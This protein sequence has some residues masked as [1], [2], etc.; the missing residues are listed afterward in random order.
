MKFKDNLG[1]VPCMFPTDL[2]VYGAIRHYFGDDVELIARSS[3]TPRETRVLAS[4]VL[5]AYKIAIFVMPLVG[6]DGN[7]WKAN[8]AKRNGFKVFTVDKEDLLN[9]EL[10]NNLMASIKEYMLDIDKKYRPM[11]INCSK[12][13]FDAER[14]CY[15]CRKNYDDESFAFDGTKCGNYYDPDVTEERYWNV[16]ELKYAMFKRDSYKPAVEYYIQKYEKAGLIEQKKQLEFNGKKCC[17][18][19]D[20]CDVNSRTKRMVCSEDGHAVI[21]E[22]P[23]TVGLYRKK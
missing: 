5:P 15:R 4:V 12:Y 20:L 19:C 3:V 7:K 2:F 14:R 6:N 17:G 21:G 16:G 1:K 23:C 8:V 10:M 11:C 18:S 13:I 22:S 9:L